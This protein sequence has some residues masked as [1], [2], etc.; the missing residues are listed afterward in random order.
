VDSVVGTERKRSKKGGMEVQQ[1]D[2]APTPRQGRRHGPCGAAIWSWRGLGLRSTSAQQTHTICWS[3][4]CEVI[5]GTSTLL[6][7]VRAS[8]SCCHFVHAKIVILKSWTPFPSLR[9]GLHYP[10]GLLVSGLW[11]RVGTWWSL[12]RSPVN[13]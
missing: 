2:G 13:A 5:L 8:V 4:N 6:D 10:R 3:F 11:N 7:S 1:G 9:S 12:F